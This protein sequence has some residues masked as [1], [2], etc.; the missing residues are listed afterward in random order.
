MSSTNIYNTLQPIKFDTKCCFFS[1]P[2]QTEVTNI[3]IQINGRN[4]FQRHD[5]NPGRHD[6]ACFAS[7]SESNL[8]IKWKLENVG[9]S[10]TAQAI[11][12][13]TKSRDTYIYT[14]SYAPALTEL[15]DIEI[16][17]VECTVF[18]NF[19]NVTSLYV[20]LR[21][22]PDGMHLSIVCTYFCL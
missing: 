8:D 17:L 10:Q 13:T 5:L 2:G 9:I 7:S 1:L 16:G 15:I 3:Y 20:L 22:V 14:S 19:R 11:T 6:F 21:V 12:S 4:V 18:A